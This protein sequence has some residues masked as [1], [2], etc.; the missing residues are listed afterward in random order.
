MDNTQ[1]TFHT[2]F[3]PCC[4]YQMTTSLHLH[5]AGQLS[6]KTTYTV[7]KYIRVLLLSCYK[8]SGHGHQC[9]GTTYA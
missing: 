9:T 8:Y 6:N 4:H 2:Y 3:S 1:H 5:Q 7:T